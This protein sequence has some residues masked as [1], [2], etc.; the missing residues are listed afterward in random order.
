MVLRLWQRWQ[1][2]LRKIKRVPFVS[3]LLVSINVIV[4]LLDNM[5]EGWFLW[6]GNLNVIDVLQKEEYGR[7]LW[8]MFL[9]A[10]LNHLFNNMI[11]LLFMGAMLEKEMGHMVFGGMYLISGICGN[12][13]SLVYKLQQGSIALSI[14][15]SG[16]VF[17]MDGLLLALVFLSPRKIS[18]VS[19]TR[20]V[21]MIALSLYN[22]FASTNIDNAAHVGG[23]VAGFVLGGLYCMVLHVKYKV[24]KRGMYNDEG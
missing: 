19:P 15:A 17:G 2:S 7:V 10:D 4:H 1:L 13:S 6:K 11:I 24:K 8:A 14:G 21:I 23:L 9:H 3:I 18:A 22:G 12:V 16:A 20:V 5:L